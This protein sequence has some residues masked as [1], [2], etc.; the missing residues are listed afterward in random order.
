MLLSLILIRI[1]SGVFYGINDKSLYEKNCITKHAEVDVIIKLLKWKNSPKQIDILVIRL[2][3]TG[4]LGNSKPCFHCLKF[5]KKHNN[6]INN[7]YYSS[8][9]NLIIKEK[10]N[11]MFTCHICKSRKK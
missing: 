4:K 6:R 2:S 9:D 7:I 5:M 1:K 3:K 8:S 10:L 11:N